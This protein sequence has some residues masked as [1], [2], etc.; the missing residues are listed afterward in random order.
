M[1][2]YPANSKTKDHKGA[3]HPSGLETHIADTADIRIGVI[4]Y[5]YWGPN[6]VRNFNS[7]N[8]ATVH[9]VCDKNRDALERIIKP[10]PGIQLT[11]D[12]D[13]ILSSPQID[14]IAV[15]TPVSTHF[16]LAKKVLQNGKHVF[17]E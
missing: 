4:G 6:I 12:L 13:D 7:I 11:S 16:E 14:A 2:A 15:V 10:Y 1:G 3:V 9:S 8:G 17:V 5:G